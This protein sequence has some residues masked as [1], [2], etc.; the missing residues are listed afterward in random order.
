MTDSLRAIITVIP[1]EGKDPVHCASFRPISLLNIDL[2][3]LIKIMADRL[4]SFVPDLLLLVKWALC[5]VGRRRTTS[6]RS[7]T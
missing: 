1:K 5:R 6:S 4:A 7:L 2:K 3:I